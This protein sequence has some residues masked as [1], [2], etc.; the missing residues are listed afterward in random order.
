MSDVEKL[1]SVLLP[2]FAQGWELLGLSWPGLSITFREVFLGG[3][4]ISLSIWVLDYV[5]G[6]GGR[7]GGQA[8]RTR[9]GR[10]HRTSKARED[11]EL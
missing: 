2:L 9:T 8:T 5:F 7:G 10:R 6:L 4:I 3:T 1:A 11:D